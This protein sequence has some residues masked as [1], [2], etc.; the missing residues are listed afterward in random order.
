VRRNIKP[1]EKIDVRMTARDKHLLLEH[2]LADPEYAERLEP[3]AGST[4]LLGRYTLDDLEDILG[5]IAAEANHT[6]DAKLQTELD[7]LY[8]HL[9][10]IQRSYDDG[11]WNDSSF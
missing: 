5:Y 2:V 3:I 1:D 10:N 4:D 9:F 6:E 7:A 11:S 8:E